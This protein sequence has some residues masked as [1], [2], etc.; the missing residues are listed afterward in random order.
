M[1]RE[2]EKTI[3]AITLHLILGIATA[4]LYCSYSKEQIPAKHTIILSDGDNF[5]SDVYRKTEKICKGSSTDPIHSL[6]IY[7]TEWGWQ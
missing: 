7:T 2:R 4:L 6:M 5:T 1:T 3:S